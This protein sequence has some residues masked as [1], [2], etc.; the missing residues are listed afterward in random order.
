[1]I[2]HPFDL[3]NV[4]IG[5]LVHVVD[6]NMGFQTWFSSILFP[7]MMHCISKQASIHAGQYCAY[8][9]SSIQGEDRV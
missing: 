7:A 9:S 8:N 6:S 5:E 3:G 4:F 1:M 2:C